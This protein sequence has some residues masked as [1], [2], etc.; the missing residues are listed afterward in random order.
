[1]MKNPGK[2][3]KTIGMNNAN[4]ADL[5]VAKAKT[6]AAIIISSTSNIKNPDLALNGFSFI[7]VNLV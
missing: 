5:V 2:S 1:M 6:I 3:I 4:S 7:V